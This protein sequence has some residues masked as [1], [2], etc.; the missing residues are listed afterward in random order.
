METGAPSADANPV[1]VRLPAMCRSAVARDFGL[2]FALL[3]AYPA[4]PAG[5]G[6]EVFVH[7]NVTTREF[8]CRFGA[9]GQLLGID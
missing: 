2:P 3:T 8:N 4:Q 5:R 1:Q 7:S 6:F 9:Q